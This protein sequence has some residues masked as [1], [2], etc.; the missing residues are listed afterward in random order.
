MGNITKKDIENLAEAAQFGRGLLAL[1]NAV[2]ASENLLLSDAAMDIVESASRATRMLERLTIAAQ[3][4]TPHATEAT[5]AV[6]VV[7]T[8][9][10]AIHPDDVEIRPQDILIQTYCTKNG[11]SWAPIMENGTRIEHL[12]TGISVSC[13]KG[14]SAHANR[15]LAMKR[16]RFILAA[17]S[18]AGTDLWDEK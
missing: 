15:A 1:L 8:H 2:T 3:G 17:L 10:S 14:R 13:D 18:Q 7:S 5:E 12:P 16:L 11:G 6:G 9:P 4:D